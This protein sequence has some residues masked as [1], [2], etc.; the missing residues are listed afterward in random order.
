[1]KI[2]SINR[3]KLVFLT[4]GILLLLVLFRSFGIEKLIFHL[5]SIGWK[6]WIVMLVILLDHVILTYAWKILINHPVKN[7]YFYKLVLARI[8]GDS[9]ASINTLGA[10][11]G[12]P[13]K[14]MYLKDIIPFKTGL[15]SVILDRTITTAANILLLLTGIIFSFFILDL[16]VYLTA[17]ALFFV[18]L[19]LF[20]VTLIIRKQKDGFLEYII[21]L[22]PGKISARFMNEKRLSKIKELDEEIGF[23]LSSS[24]NLKKFFASL[25]IRYIAILVTGVLEV[26]LF[27][28]YIGVNLSI[29]D[30]MFTYIFGLFLTGLIFFMPANL[31]TSEGSYSLALKFLGYD[32]A[33]GLTLGIL[34]RIR[35]FV[36]S[37]IGILILFHAGFFKKDKNN[38]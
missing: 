8:A 35:S 30:S 34:R 26:Y 15:A 16:P 11:A 22:M 13:I 33:L 29:Q 28:N 12:E 32:P 19:L 5:R 21:N 31:G 7:S 14:A 6:F 20:M 3:S 23:I 1:M 24:N 25:I 18:I 9:T 36:W 10:M 37:A 17:S 4:A 38:V 27:I 2:S